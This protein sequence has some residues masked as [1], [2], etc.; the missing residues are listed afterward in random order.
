MTTFL[1]KTTAILLAMTLAACSSMRVVADGRDA[2]DTV[3][4]D[5]TQGLHAGERLVLHGR[6]GTAQAMLFERMEG[7]VLVG[8]EGKEGDRDVRV[9]LAQVV[10]IER[11][12]ID[13]WKT[14]G[15]VAG[16]TAGVLVVANMLANSI[17]NDIRD[18]VRENRH[19]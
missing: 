5:S 11:K 4:R 6:D 2:V 17:V 16:I 1:R 18:D 3:A 8:K 9:A 15:L 12:E 14:T 10:R 7:D 19:K 13:G